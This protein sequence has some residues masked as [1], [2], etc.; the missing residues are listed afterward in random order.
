MRR[1]TIPA[2]R[3]RPLRLGAVIVG[4]LACALVLA[5]RA[6]RAAGPEPLGDAKRGAYVFAAGDCENCHTDKKAKGAFLAGGPPMVTD[7][8]AFFAPNI[9]SDRKNGL[10]AW[11]YDEFHRAMRE[12]KG[13][14]GELL[15][16]VFPYPPSPA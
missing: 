5:P 15:Y 16:P 12:G 10:G 3:P 1:L 4:A 2:L 9:T 6:P 13:K 14:S 11:S 7:F 8:G